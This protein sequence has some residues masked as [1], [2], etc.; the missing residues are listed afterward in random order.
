VANGRP[1]CLGGEDGIP[2]TSMM[3]VINAAWEADAPPAIVTTAVLDYI[4][5]R[6]QSK[7]ANEIDAKAMEMLVGLFPTRVEAGSQHKV[8][9]VMCIFEAAL[10]RGAAC[11]ARLA[12]L[13]MAAGGVDVVDQKLQEMAGNGILDHKVFLEVAEALCVE[14]RPHHDGTFKVLE[15]LLANQPDMPAGERIRLCAAIHFRHLS[16][17][18]LEK[19]SSNHLIPARC[20][21]QGA[22]GSLKDLEGRV[23]RQK[24]A[25]E[26]QMRDMQAVIMRQGEEIKELRTLVARMAKDQ[27]ALVCSDTPRSC[28]DD[29]GHLVDVS[30]ELNALISEGNFEGAFSRALHSNTSDLLVWT[31]YNTKVENIF[32]SRPPKLTQATTLALVQHLSCKLG[33]DTADTSLKLSWLSEGL[34]ALDREFD[35]GPWGPLLYQVRDLLDGH[36]ADISD[37]DLNHGVAQQLREALS[38]ITTMIDKLE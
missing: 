2:S 17:A 23:D 8:E 15:L 26:Q 21:A 18:T 13:A 36:A 37:A 20:I 12:Q 32:R 9:D 27:P 33:P 30:I 6:L 14:E 24:R 31:C 25:S 22:A 34:L 19:A 4:K 11:K 5:A 10:E 7:H 3:H 38:I 29:E 1:L 16:P 35:N 28:G